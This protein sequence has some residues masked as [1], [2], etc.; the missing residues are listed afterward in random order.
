MHL[1][2]LTRVLQ[3]F[4]FFLILI[5]AVLSAQNDKAVI[6]SIK[7][8][9]KESVKYHTQYQLKESIEEAA[10]VV[11]LAHKINNAYYKAQGYNNIG[12]N[13]ELIKDY[14]NA[15]INYGKALVN[16]QQSDSTFLI[17]WLYNNI[18]NVYSEGFRDIDKALFYY[19]KAL[20]IARELDRPNDELAPTLNIGWTFIDESKPNEAYPFLIDAQKIINE[21]GDKTASVQINFL[22][23]KYHLLR[24]EYAQ[25]DIFFEKATVQGMELNMLVELSDVWLAK[26]QM[27]SEM[28]K[29]DLAYKALTK[30]NEYKDKVFNASNL[31]QLEI[32]KARFS[33]DEYRRELDKTRREKEFQES[34]AYKNR[35][36]T[37][38]A[39]I[40]AFIFWVLLVTIFYN[41]KAKNRLTK[42]LEQN[43]K[44][45]EAAKDEAEKLSQLKS[46][47]ISTV[48]HELRT[49]LYGVVGL[50]SLLLENNKLDTKDQHFLKSLKFS[51]DY[52]LNLINDVLQIS[53]IES[54]KVK[55]HNTTTN[56]RNLIDNIVGSF[57]YQLEHRHNK[58]HVEL[59]EGLPIMLK[60]DS[61]RISQILINLLGNA[62]KFT[63]NGNIWLRLKVKSIDGQ[64]VKL[65]VEI[66]D[67]G[68]GIP[69]DKQEAIFE[70]FSQIE[71]E[72]TEYQGTG[73]G[74]SIVKKL[75]S[76]Y[77]SDIFLESKQGKGS[78]FF[79]DLN[80]E[81]DHE[82]EAVEVKQLAEDVPVKNRHILVVEDNKINQIVTQNILEKENFAC[83][84]VSNGEAAIKVVEEQ[85]F[86]L[87]LMS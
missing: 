16:A 21:L 71:R 8:H 56:I 35:I 38:V 30:H 50:T 72:K 36:I 54:N 40:T 9:L 15:E 64:F 86:D 80:L 52:L 45:L 82:A 42:L 37:I 25:A 18:A 7:K 83:T 84:I 74:L 29:P 48:S 20:T 68:P 73:L 24:K 19:Q 46:Q 67:D 53:K 27:Y 44:E 4:A 17:S 63:S 58:M 5:P 76:L 60:L 55:I 33:V 14:E 47:F 81:I 70:N 59:D 41:Y 13:Y 49:P 39:F 61:V 12:F 51:G 10:K 65:G 34:L 75:V 11:D 62:V 32:T 3:R 28:E 2:N 87:I 66:E 1:I 22:F 85:E 78:K 57:N 79:F 69:E 77:G 31:S 23:G 6:D 26:S 43:N